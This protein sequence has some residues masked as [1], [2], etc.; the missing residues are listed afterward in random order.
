MLL[1]VS[2][3]GWRLGFLVFI[4]ALFFAVFE[5]LS[6]AYSKTART[7]EDIVREVQYS[8]TVRNKT[9]RL[10]HGAELWVYAPVK[11]TSV[12]D[13]EKLEASHPYDLIGDEL[14][15]QILHF[16]FKELP[17]YST[18]LITIHARLKLR[19]EPRPGKVQ[20]SEAFLKPED[21]I[22]SDEPEIRT[23]SRSLSGRNGMETARKINDWVFQNLKYEGYIRGD[24]GALYALKNRRGDC[25][26]FT[27]LFCALCRANGIPA[28]AIGG[29]ICPENMVLKPQQY[30]NWAE[31]YVDGTW[32]ICD[33]QK[34]VFARDEA[35]Y[36]AMNI[37]GEF[38]NNNPMKGFHRFRF[39]GDGLD[40][41]MNSQ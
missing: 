28:R 22:E 20:D 9:N 26:E 37:I 23:L 4:L 10:M 39:Q 1:P 40:V 30:H 14:E 3:R 24:R 2:A 18:K 34:N 38:C 5:L 32:R 35:N 36:V 17:P 16:K 21:Y 15:N 7:D 13:C 33:P 6:P 29:Y 31:F 12:Q 19:D 27:Y 41:I 25:T 11:M 8:F